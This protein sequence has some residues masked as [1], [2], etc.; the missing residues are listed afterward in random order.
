MSCDLIVILDLLKMKV[1]SLELSKFIITSYWS[2]FSIINTS[3][4]LYFEGGGHGT[5]VILSVLCK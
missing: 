3:E 5:S 4:I 1:V 2:G